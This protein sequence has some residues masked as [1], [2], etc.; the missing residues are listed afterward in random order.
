M[1]FL[2]ANIVILDLE[3]IHVTAVEA[4][5]ILVHFHEVKV[6]VR[7]SIDTLALLLRIVFLVVEVI[8][9]CDSFLETVTDSLAAGFFQVL[10]PPW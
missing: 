8:I 5:K 10:L 1:R 3:V 6:E 4:L 2:A 7:V 9:A